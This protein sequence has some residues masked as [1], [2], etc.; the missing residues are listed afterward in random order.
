LKPKQK[1]NKAQNRALPQENN[2]KPVKKSNCLGA[3][4]L[5]QKIGAPKQLQ[6]KSRLRL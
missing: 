4:I 6:K 3:P 1:K 5:G 2:D